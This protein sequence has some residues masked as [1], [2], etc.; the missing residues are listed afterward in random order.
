MAKNFRV[1]FAIRLVIGS[2]SG[3]AAFAGIGAAQYVATGL[4]LGA[5]IGINGNPARAIAPVSPWAPGLSVGLIAALL[6]TVR[7]IWWDSLASRLSS[8][9]VVVVLLTIGNVMFGDYYGTFGTLG[10]PMSV[11]LS[12]VA[13]AVRTASPLNPRTKETHDHSNRLVFTFQSS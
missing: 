5:V 7:S 3:F 10:W 12:D 11:A 1:S 9:V 13:S 2:F 8:A 6:Y 4:N